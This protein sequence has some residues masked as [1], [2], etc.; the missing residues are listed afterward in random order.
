MQALNEEMTRAGARGRRVSSTTRLER[1]LWA[2]TQK[3]LA[4]PEHYRLIFSPD[5]DPA[6]HPDVALAGAEAFRT[7]LGAV[8]EA[9]G[10]TT[11][12]PGLK[13]VTVAALLFSSVHGLIDLQ[14]SGH[15]EPGKGLSEP[16][17]L[18]RQLVLL[19]VAPG[20]SGQRSS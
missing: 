6:L 18:I 12:A 9:H 15:G 3:A 19:V 11:T 2:H 7:L 17:G 8:S 5:V 13:P 20:S 4:C 1:M 10:S 14:L 16:R